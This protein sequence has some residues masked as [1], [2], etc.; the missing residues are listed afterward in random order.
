MGGP[1]RY[2]YSFF[3]FCVHRW[4]ALLGFA[5]A[6]LK[7]RRKNAKWATL[8]VD[9]TAEALGVPKQQVRPTTYSSKGGVALGH[10]LQPP[11]HDTCTT[12]RGS[13][14]NK[15]GKSSKG[16]VIAAASRGQPWPRQR[17][18]TPPRLAIPPPQSTYREAP[19]HS[20]PPP[21]SP[22]F[23][24]RLVSTV[25]CMYTRLRACCPGC[26]TGAWLSSASPES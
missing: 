13:C 7:K 1:E 25:L 6:A 26:R 15:Y 17:E 3:F 10:V 8:K 23:A 18:S 2:P 21:S 19:S 16:G 11:W 14:S 4:L 9:E 12:S 22:V 5:D 20:P 24:S